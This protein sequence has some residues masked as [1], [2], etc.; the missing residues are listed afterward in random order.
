M[1]T[2]ANVEICFNIKFRIFDCDVHKTIPRNGFVKVGV[3][4][5][6]VHKTIPWNGF[7][8]ILYD[9]DAHKTIPRDGLLEGKGKKTN[10]CFIISLSKMHFE[11]PPGHGK[12]RGS[13]I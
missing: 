5:F 8:N 1:W 10:D 2:K 11:K 9:L 4:D 13:R 7:V 12:R 3:F 6:G